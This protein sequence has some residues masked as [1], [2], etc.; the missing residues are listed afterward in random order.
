MV[1]QPGTTL[2]DLYRRSFEKY[3]NRP[4]LTIDDTTWS[5]QEIW[6]ASDRLVAALYDKG[7]RKGDRLGIMTSNCAEYVMT[8]LACIQAGFV[9]VPLND[10]LSQEKFKYML[11]D[12]EAKAV[13]VSE[14]LIDPLQAIL[15]NLDRVE[16]VVS[17]T[18]NSLGWIES[19]DDFIDT[20]S[21]HNMNVEPEDLFRL[22]YTGGTTGKPKGVKHTHRNFSMALYAHLIELDIKFGERMLLMTPLPHAA[23][24]FLQAAMLRGGHA[25]VTNGFE[26]D[27]FLDIVE[28]GSI[29][30]SFMVPTM[31]YEVLDHGTD[32]HNL[33]SIETIAYGASPIAQNRLE[34]ALSTFGDVFVQFYGQSEVPNIGTILPKADHELE[35]DEKMTSC[36]KPSIM[37]DA[38]I[39]DV[40]NKESTESLPPG[41]EGEILLRAP[42]SMVGYHKK[43]E[44]TDTT[45]VNGWVR[46]G[47]I[48]KKDEN[49]YVYILDRDSDMVISGGMNVYTTEVEDVIS[50]HPTVQEVAVIGIPHEK[51]GEAIHAVVVS[52]KQTTSEDDLIEFTN[53]LLS[54]YEK[55]KSIEFVDNIPKTPYGKQDKK[56]LR[57][58]YWENVDRKVS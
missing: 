31:L 39:S 40:Q 5:Y 32:G 43:P 33:S 37:T 44:K 8:E 48:G 14:S 21:T 54:K 51:W 19:F 46:T 10:L 7:L 13:V 1:R 22:I 38:R 12:S 4:L 28:H 57:E 17:T 56:A 3:G 47:D 24:A 34:E 49:G 52:D 2:Q 30:W 50:R 58:P 41:E 45:L 18:D 26:P 25:V 9:S 53:D 42:Y 27:Q 20:D 11:D 35:S 15:P 16:L 55:P 29:T 23:G 6:K 36:G